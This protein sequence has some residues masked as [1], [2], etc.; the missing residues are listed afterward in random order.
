MTES[1]RAKSKVRILVSCTK[2]QVNRCASRLHKRTSL[3]LILNT[4]KYLYKWLHQG[5]STTQDGVYVVTLGQVDDAR[6]GTGYRP[7]DEGG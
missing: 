4:N 3:G 6:W 7:M 5:R 2:E 1:K